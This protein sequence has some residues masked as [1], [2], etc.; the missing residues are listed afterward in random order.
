MTQEDLASARR[1]ALAAYER[2]DPDAVA[3]LKAALLAQPNDGGL[4]IAEARARSAIGDAEALDRLQAILRR[5]PDW[6][7]GHVAFAQLRWEM[8]ERETFLEEFEAAL[9][10]LPGHAGL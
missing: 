1:E 5:A 8:G 2:G 4:L 6:L 9:R 3:K 10:R 7:D